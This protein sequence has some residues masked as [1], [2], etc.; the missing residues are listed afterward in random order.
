MVIIIGSLQIH[1]TLS[2][3]FIVA[4]TSSSSYE[5]MIY[6]VNTKFFTYD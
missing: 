3:N 5:C 6:D 1:F 2:D 4:L